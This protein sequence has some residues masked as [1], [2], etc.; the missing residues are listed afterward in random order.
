MKRFFHLGLLG[1]AATATVMAAPFAIASASAQSFPILEA[2]DLTD[3][4]QEQVQNIFQDLRSDLDTI[5]TDAQQ[6]QFQEVYRESQDFRAAAT[7]ID[8][9]TD[10]QK[11]EIRAAMQ[12]SRGELSGVLTAA[13]Q[14][15]LRSLMQERRQ[16][17]R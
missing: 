11:A 10:D 9:L 13:Q 8:N 7:A 5:L 12:D 14:A 1:L 4:Q 17:R 6:S 2:L 15:E 16:N 3:E